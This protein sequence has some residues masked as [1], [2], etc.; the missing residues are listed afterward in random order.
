M[1]LFSFFERL[2]DATGAPPKSSIPAQLG[3]FYWHFLRQTPWLMVGLLTTAFLVA[4]LDASVPAL[5]GWLVTLVSTHQRASILSEAWPDLFLIAAVVGVLRPLAL[6]VQTLLANQTLAPGLGNLVRW[7]S[8]WHVARRVWTFFQNDFAGSVANR[9]VNTGPSLRETVLLAA[10]ALWYL[11]VYGGSAM[12]LLASLDGPLIFPVACWF[13]GYALLLWR[14]VPRIRVRSRE[15]SE[16]RSILTGRLVDC[17]ANI[18]TLKLYSR[19]EREDEYIRSAIDGHTFSY[20]RHLRL[21]TELNL[22]LSIINAAMIVSASALAVEL[23]SIGRVEIG[24]IAMTLPLTWQIASIAGRVTQH[25]TSLFENMGVVEDGMRAIAAPAMSEKESSGKLS[26]TRGA[27]E[28]AD[29]RFGYD[30][31]RPILDGVDLAVAPGER[32]GLIGESGAGKST[33]VHLLLRL[34]DLDGGRIRIDGQ[35]IADVSL[36]SLWRQVAVV[37]QD[38]ALLNRSVRDNIRLGKPDASDDEVRE[39]AR[40]VHAL[41]FIETLRD[42]DGNCGLDAAT[43]DRG[44][45]LSGGQRQ[46]IVIARAVL[47]NSPILVLDEATSALD[48]ATES[49]VQEHLLELMRGRTVIAIAHRLSTL[50]SMDRV[51]RLENG[52]IHETSWRPGQRSVESSLR[53]WK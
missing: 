8:H 49:A 53:E 22:L 27:I 50:A 34:F 5:F 43:G 30:K 33:L 25:A 21:T 10:N 51:I 44:T 42:G 14:Y 45:K 9:V 13:A 7:Q 24:A 40:R 41:E 28:F 36:E 39:V 3:R 52:R 16:E 12:L 19:Q 37:T 47:K 1:R 31:T 23:W 4:A 20:R 6:S 18:V 15:V 35:D 29:V 38:S 32:V 2:V 26:V 46:R 11:I 17:Y 48:D